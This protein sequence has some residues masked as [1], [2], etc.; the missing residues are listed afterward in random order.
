MIRSFYK[1]RLAIAV[2]SLMVTT[3]ATA[4][5]K[6]EPKKNA[7]EDIEVIEITGIAA[8]LEENLNQKRYS[9]TFTDAIVAEDIG[10]L[11]D[12]N[13]AET[14]QRVAGVQIERE[15]GEGANVTI[16]G[17]RENRVEVN[18]RTLISAYGRG[19]NAGLMSYFPSEIVGSVTVDKVLTADMTD[20]ALGGTINIKTR[21]PLDK[22]GLWGGATVKGTYA[23]LN[24]D[25]GYKLSG[26][27][28]NSFL[29][30]TFGIMVGVVYEDRPITEDR[31]YSNGDWRSRK[32]FNK[33]P[34]S[35][36]EDTINSVPNPYYY[37]YDLRYQRKEESREKSAVNLVAQWRP[38]DNLDIN[39]DVLY[40]EFDYDRHRGWISATTDH[41][42]DSYEKDS[43]VISEHD[44][45]VAGTLTNSV[46]GHHEGYQQPQDFLTG[47]V[48]AT[49]YAENGATIF[50]EFAHTE[51]ES[52]ADQQYI[53]LTKKDVT[54]SYDL[55][56]ADVP[57]INLPDLSSSEGLIAGTFYD[58][59][60]VNSA[61]EDSVRIDFTYPMDGIFTEVKVGARYSD[62]NAEQ[63]R[64]GKRG[65]GPDDEPGGRDFSNAEATSFTRVGLNT[66][67]VINLGWAQ[68]ALIHMN[69]NDVLPSSG[70]QLPGDVVAIDTHKIG[71]GR[72][73]YSDVFYDEPMQRFP[74]TSSEV[75]DKVES[76][77]LRFDYELSDW[78]GN[79]GIRYAKTT[80]EVNKFALVDGQYEVYEDEGSYSDVLPSLVAVREL[81][82]DLLLRLGASKTISRPATSNYAKADRINL[83][84]DDPETPDDE[85]V[86][87]TASLANPNL[88]PQRGEQYDASLEWYFDKQSALAFALFYKKLD[89][90]VINES[91]ETTIPG[92]GDQIFLVTTQTNGEGGKIKGFEVAYQQH[93]SS[94]T[95]DLLN[96]IGMSVN[97]T[98]LDNKTDETDPRTGESIGI[99]GVSTNSVNIQVYYEDE[100]LSARLL[101]NWRD[102]YYDRL[103]PYSTT[104]AIDN[105]GQPSLDA[106]I[107]YR[108]GNGFSMELQAINLLDSP[109]EEYAGW[110]QYVA[111]YAE[112]GTRYHLGLSYRF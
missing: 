105:K 103:D 33:P 43:W 5:Q 24:D 60:N 95:I 53:S 25:S 46:A 70:V 52:T 71:N 1:S 29:D 75:G 63:Y 91:V 77:Y 14:L 64:I 54:F 65:V 76:A 110:E 106:S 78:H 97:Y 98:Y 86:N 83:V 55:R 18:G 72:F 40:A 20:G 109:K 92:Y 51:S 74:E 11:P 21:K 112:T 96:N 26:L 10:K 88:E 2:A 28:S 69:F 37:M 99:Q 13:L 73:G 19:S 48:N 4:Q 62:I 58:N 84:I 80:T 35:W 31:F 38:S 6:E 68:D 9:D 102:D 44:S 85:S 87:S 111:T 66:S 32:P 101:Y 56:G 23:D 79:V 27:M 89:N 81:A 67:E 93:F 22:T 42:L 94:S 104:T 50:A 34:E 16:R 15:D 107:K 3:V 8:S 59:R 17:I 57:L 12:D 41:Y 82:D 30:D 61:S 7:D 49:W 100:A 39:A 47:G 45:R 36:G 90:Q 108:L